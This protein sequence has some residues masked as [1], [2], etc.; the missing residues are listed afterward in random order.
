MQGNARCANSDSHSCC[1]SRRRRPRF[2]STAPRSS[3][4]FDYDDYHFVTPVHTR[5]RHRGIS[6]TVGCLRHRA[7]LL[8][9]ADHCSS[10]PLRFEALGINSTAHHAL[11]LILF[12]VAAA[13]AG[14]LVF[15]LHHF[16][17]RSA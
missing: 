8:P 16:L 12:A 11:S 7:P 13:L 2:F 3:Y 5:R 10:L 14:W 15:R 1:S 4:G 17:S 6:R 9:A